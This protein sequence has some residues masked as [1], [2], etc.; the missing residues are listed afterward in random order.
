MPKSA[1][2]LA[3]LVSCKKLAAV[4]CSSSSSS[5][6]TSIFPLL[7]GVD[8]EGWEGQR[9]VHTHINTYEQFRVAS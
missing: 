1:A 4:M 7:Y 6:S 9:A 8:A 2:P 3:I 5:S